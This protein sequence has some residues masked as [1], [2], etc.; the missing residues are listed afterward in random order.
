[1]VSMYGYA[2][3]IA[4]TPLKDGLLHEYK[5]QGKVTWMKAVMQNSVGHVIVCSKKPEDVRGEIFG[6]S[7]GNLMGA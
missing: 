3:T 5:M 2:H 4:D 6:L 7:E 1:M